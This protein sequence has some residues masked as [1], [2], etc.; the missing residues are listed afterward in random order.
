MGDPVC[1]LASQG[2]SY[3]SSGSNAVRGCRKLATDNNNCLA[4]GN[5]F[6]Y[7]TNA[8]HCGGCGKDLDQTQGGVTCEN[9]QANCILD[10]YEYCDVPAQNGMSAVTG[11]KNLQLDAMNC[12][13]C[14]NVLSD[15]G[16]AGVGCTQGTANC[17]ANGYTYCDIP[18]ANGRP[19]VKGCRDLEVDELN[20]GSCGRRIDQLTGGG[21]TCI[22]A[23]PTCNIEEE[24]YCPGVG[25]NDPDIGCVNL[26]TN[27]NHCTNCN[28]S[29]L[30]RTVNPLL[31]H[32]GGCGKEVVN[33]GTLLGG[34]STRTCING[35]KGCSTSGYTYCENSVR[36]EGCVN[37]LSSD[38]NCTECFKS[39]LELDI[40]D[41]DDNCRGCGDQLKTHLGRQVSCDVDIL[42]NEGTPVCEDDG[43]FDYCTSTGCVDKSVD[44][45]H[46]GK[47][48][49]H[50]TELDRDENCRSCGDAL[51]TRTDPVSG[52]QIG[53]FCDTSNEDLDAVP[54]ILAIPTCEDLTLSYC[55]EF[56]AGC[57]SLSG[58]L[59]H[60]GSCGNRLIQLPE[61]NTVTCSP[62][63]LPVCDKPGY[64][65]CPG[66]G[67]VNLLTNDDHC[68]DCDTPYTDLS[69]AARHC[70]GCNID[71]TNQ[72]L[73][74]DYICINNVATCVTN[75]AC[76]TNPSTCVAD[77]DLTF[78]PGAG[79]VNLDDDANHCTQC[80]LPFTSPY[81]VSTDNCRSC[82][83]VLYNNGATA[84]DDETGLPA[85]VLPICVNGPDCNFLDYTYCDPVPTF[86]SGAEI[87]CVNL[88]TDDD[89][90]GD[91]GE[92]FKT[93]T[94]TSNCRNCGDLLYDNGDIAP[95]CTLDSEGDG[96]PTCG[97]A[98][99][100]FTYC[101]ATLVGGVLT[102][103]GCVNKATD[104]DNCTAC[105]QNFKG[106]TRVDNCRECG[107]A[108]VTRNSG[109]VNAKL[110]QCR[111]AAN[112]TQLA[113]GTQDGVPGCADTGFSYCETVAGAN[114]IGCVNLLND[115]DNCGTCNVPYTDPSFQTTQEQKNANCTGCNKSFK[116][117]PRV[118]NCRQCGDDLRTNN[119]ITPVCTLDGS[120]EGSPTCGA[121]NPGLTYCETAEFLNDIGCVDLATDDANCGTCGVPYT[122]SS[123]DATA[124]LRNAN[125]TG[126]G[127]NYINITDPTVRI[128]NCRQCN[129]AL[130]NND[131]TPECT[132]DG[133][134]DG[135]PYCGDDN[136]GFTYCE[137]ALYEND[138]GCVNLATDD[139]NCGNCN[140]PYT[141]SSLDATR[142]AN[143]TGCGILFT[144][145]TD[146]T[147]RMNN[148]RKCNDI[149]FTNTL[150]NNITPE[151][152][153]GESGDGTPYCGDANVGFTYCE[154]ALYANDIGCVDLATDTANCGTCGNSCLS[155][156]TCVGGTC[157]DGTVPP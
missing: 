91:C 117:L 113:T 101:D 44:D 82:G 58:N 92:S 17:I 135:T 12:G 67:C 144:S 45:E 137:S 55:D 151:C 78:C 79:C 127:I 141:D 9:A 40:Q 35:V 129:D 139:N 54:P 33:N 128:N 86:D 142:N 104:N 74:G 37:L 47:C 39:Y 148:C 43:N 56:Q 98:N 88:N 61:G 146:S 4:C 84:I 119:S 18:A 96:L 81:L 130:Y 62:L 76:K 99:V 63:G 50:F 21:A 11:C 71:T 14:G 2:Y 49:Q 109:T 149:L 48:D 8:D 150:T 1:N 110:P 36:K 97:S 13:T 111:N 26:A 27:D 80:S 136:V 19:A 121:A 89:H 156:E 30:D 68:G 103:I 122:D 64:S 15:V 25:V 83:D 7:S 38:N 46:C 157:T 105:G 52:E 34:G 143:C 145:I 116:T 90:C 29:Y 112:P 57:V 24:S 31:E 140:V 138:I 133:S 93:T 59:D 66:T 73:E 32:C 106:L 94:R 152:T 95:E 42:T 70:G 155:G 87:G 154:T 100:G 108:L 102:D 114:D 20:C 126:C 132:L 53:A 51:I 3:C 41:R 75:P 134:G 5:T 23:Q 115:N 131:I 6:D 124:A 118:D 16:G 147:V 22:D 85:D 65:Y 69:P 60:C 123:F 10:G 77:P 107:D 125:C 72:R 153:L 120:G 28:T